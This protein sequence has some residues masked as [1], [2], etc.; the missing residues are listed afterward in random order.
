MSIT[1]GVVRASFVHVFQ[2]Q[3]PPGGGEPKYQIT[4]LIPQND[5]QTLN[6]L[7]AEI[8]R[9]KQA[10]AQQF[11]GQMTGLKIPL[12]DGDG[13]MPSGGS[14]GE[15]CRGH[16]VLRASSKDQPAVVDTNMQPVL[17]PSDIYS[18]CYVRASVNFFTYNQP[19]NKGVGCGLNAVQ[20]ISDGEPL[21]NRVTPEEAFGGA[22][23][24]AGGQSQTY[25]PNTYQAPVP[26]TYQTPAQNTYQAP[27]QGMPYPQNTAYQAPV[28]PAY[29]PQNQNAYPAQQIDPITG[30][31]IAP[32][33]VMGI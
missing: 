30:M 33:G 26:N 10:N 11:G 27:V 29:Q 8:E 19:M 24:Y 31:P 32:G 14:W 25:Q 17:N 18:G 3:T 9:V 22:N 6:A 4:L 28:P 15:E 13:A 21:A 16:M 12:Y 23:A 5:T 1:T 2:P 20:K 7:N